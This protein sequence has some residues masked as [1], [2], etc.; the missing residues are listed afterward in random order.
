MKTSAL[1]Y[2]LALV[3]AAPAAHAASVEAY[4]NRTIQPAGP[5]TG[6]SGIN[7]FNVEGSDNGSFASYG[8]ARFDLSSLKSGFDTTYGAGQWMVDSIVLELTQSNASFTTDGGVSVYFTDI[9][10]PAIENMAL[11]YDFTGDFA[12]ASHVV[13]YNFAAV[14]S[15][16]VESHTLFNRAQGNSAGGMNLA[17]DILADNIVTLALVDADTSVAATYAGFNNNT[18]A[19]PTL[20]VNVSAVPEPEAYALM[21]AGLGLVGFFAR[22]QARG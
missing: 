22:R 21:L 3:L 17:A 13:S 15:G 11:Q 4:D 16:T 8:V 6:G 20:V 19:G 2:A 12:D 7:F 1:I 5:R 10:S 18:Y 14:S 9:D